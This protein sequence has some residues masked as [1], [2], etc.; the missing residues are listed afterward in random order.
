MTRGR[1]RC[2][3]R[4]EK[5]TTSSRNLLTKLAVQTALLS[6]LVLTVTA[7]VAQNGF[8]FLDDTLYA[9]NALVTEG[10]TAHGIAFA[11]TSM[12]A[13]YWHPL[14][15]LSH[16]LDFELFGV[17]PG[18]H[19]LT[20]ALL[21]SITAALLFLFL[22]RVGANTWA[23]AAGGLLWALHPLRVE[24]VAWMAERKDVLCALFFMATL[25]AYARY[26]E[27]PLLWVKFWQFAPTRQ[28]VPGGGGLICLSM[29]I[30]LNSGCSASF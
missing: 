2:R 14:A 5:Q 8:V 28:Y 18:A 25:L 15:Y 23:S 6:L 3:R 21:H 11:F 13:L 12:T 27:R 19:H 7:K 26:V 9:G 16:E 24:S 4:Q 17:N 20:S 1:T 29:Q 22:R 30:G 10:L